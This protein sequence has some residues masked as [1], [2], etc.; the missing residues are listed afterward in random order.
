MVEVPWLILR[1]SVVSSFFSTV[2]TGEKVGFQEMPLVYMPQRYHPFVDT[3][4]NPKMYFQEWPQT[5]N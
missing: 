3:N 2:P 1:L 5:F 4:C